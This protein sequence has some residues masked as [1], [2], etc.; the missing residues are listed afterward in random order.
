MIPGLSYHT[1]TLAHD[2][3]AQACEV[4]QDDRAIKW[5]MLG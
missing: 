1:P 5:K 2:L 4:V 3:Q